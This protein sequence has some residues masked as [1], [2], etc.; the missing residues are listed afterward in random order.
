MSDTVMME[1]KN[2]EALN[3]IEKSWHKRQSTITTFDFVICKTFF[4]V[5]VSFIWT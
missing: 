2:R 3:C 1:I 5:F 4:D